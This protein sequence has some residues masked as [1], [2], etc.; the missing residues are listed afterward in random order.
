[1]TFALVG[2]RIDPPDAE[3]IRFPLRNREVVRTRL[4]ALFDTPVAGTL[5]CSA[6]CG[7]DLLALD[8]ARQCKWRRRVILPFE[9]ARF[10]DTSVTDR[11]GDWAKLYDRTLEE[12]TRTGDVVTESAPA[13]CEPYAF[14]N[15]CILEEA[16]R[17]AA[18]SGEHP[19]AV[20]VW[21]GEAYG[22]GDLSASFAAAARSK[23]MNVLQ[24]STLE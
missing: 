5:V 12:V 4:L 18:M 23:G 17:I 1:M 21:D 16:A 2:R 24:V 14:A 11:P 19:S 10:R 7:A 22:A 3:R 13:D 20:V 15:D 9:A 6:G 8:A